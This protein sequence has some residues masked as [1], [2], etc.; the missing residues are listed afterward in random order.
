MTIE[1][2]LVKTRKRFNGAI[3]WRVES[4]DGIGLGTVNKTSGNGTMWINS[5][6]DRIYYGT[7]QAAVKGLIWSLIDR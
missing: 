3:I 6:E 5:N 4:D 7:R 1:F 2:R